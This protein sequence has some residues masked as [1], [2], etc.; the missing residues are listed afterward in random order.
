MYL[1]VF[2]MKERLDQMRK[3]LKEKKRLC[4][5]LEDDIQQIERDIKTLEDRAEDSHSSLTV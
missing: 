3:L 5:L 2:D 4:E 1:G